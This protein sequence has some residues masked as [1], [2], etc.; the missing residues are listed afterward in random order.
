MKTAIL[1]VDDDKMVLGS[2]RLQLSRHYSGRHMLEFAEDAIEGLEVIE[3]LT[4][5]GVVTLLVISDWIMPGMKGDEFLMRVK[6][7]YPD[8]ETIM[9]TGQP[10]GEILDVDEIKGYSSAVLYKPWKEKELV[11]TIDKLVE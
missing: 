10:S 8:I 11:E 9:L 6:N 4:N 3:D 2:L 5:S 7:S 1:V